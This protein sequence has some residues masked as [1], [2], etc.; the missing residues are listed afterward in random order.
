MVTSLFTA[1]VSG[2]VAYH[3][4]RFVASEFEYETNAFAG[5]PAWTCEIVIPA[6][7]G[8]IALR[9]A[10]YFIGDLRDLVAGAEGEAGAG[11][12]AGES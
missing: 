1:L 12:G 7:F 4:A 11:A 6:A 9:Y 2:T 8:L 3:A 5:V 10:L